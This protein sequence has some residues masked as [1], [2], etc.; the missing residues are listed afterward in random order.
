MDQSVPNLREALSKVPGVSR[1]W[2]EW[3]LDDNDTMTL[4]IEVTFDTDPLSPGFQSSTV[5]AVRKCIM[6]T[7]RTTTL[8][9]NDYRI[10][11]AL[12]TPP[13]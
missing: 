3:A 6:D 4:V 7:L 8:G 9:I 1:T 2:Y 10:V 13:G 12:R 11:P 5:R